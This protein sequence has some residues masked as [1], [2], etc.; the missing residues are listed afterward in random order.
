MEPVD[1]GLHLSAAMATQRES[2]TGTSAGVADVPPGRDSFHRG[3]SR[4]SQV[5][6]RWWPPVL[7]CG[8]YVVLAI[9]E[10]GHFGSIGSSHITG[11]RSDDAILQ[12]WWLAWMADALPHG[13]NIF[14][15]QWQNYPAGENFG[16]NDSMLPLGLLFLPITKLLARLSAGTSRYVWPLRSQQVRCASCSDVG[17][18]GGQPPSSEDCSTAF[19][20]MPPTSPVVCCFSPSCRCL[21]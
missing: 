11:T 1:G 18:R 3:D 12:V 7:C 13:H 4:Q 21:R 9:L 15:T 2:P 20:A 14:L 10:F 5:R 8:L 6:R 16:V 19:P 17:R